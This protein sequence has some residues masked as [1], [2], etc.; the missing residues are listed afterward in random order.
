[1]ISFRD[2]MF[3]GTVLLVS[4][5]VYIHAYYDGMNSFCD[6]NEN[7]QQDINGKNYCVNIHGIREFDY[8]VGGNNEIRFFDNGT[9][10]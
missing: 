3:I 4:T 10:R 6:V 9:N 2:V 8:N 1:M 7:I 5:M